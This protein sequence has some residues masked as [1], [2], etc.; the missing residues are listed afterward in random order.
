[1]ESRP[2]PAGLELP[3]LVA[4]TKPDV[5]R[6]TS[7]PT[8]FAAENRSLVELGQSLATLPRA[9]LQKLADVA[10]GL[11]EAHAVGDAKLLENLSKFAAA[12]YKSLASRDRLESELASQRGVEVLAASAGHDHHRLALLQHELRSHLAPAK[13]AC[14]LLQRGVLDSAATKRMCAIIDRQVDGMTRIVDELL[15]D[16]PL[17]P[18][19]VELHRREM[20]LEELIARSVELVAPLMAA[21]KHTLL[22]DIRTDSLRVEADELWLLHAVQNVISNA[23]KYT[24]P[25]GRIEVRVARDGAYAVISVHDTGVGLAPEQRETIFD[26]YMQAAQGAGRP[27]AGGLGVGLHFARFLIEAHG[28]DI[29]ATSKGLGR[30]SVFTIRLPCVPTCRSSGETAAAHAAA[31]R[32]PTCGT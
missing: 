4:G 6:P 17:R 28:G 5:G 26:L 7:R 24:D 31:Q 19:G 15:E 20:A 1:M 13:N 3:S 11:C 10:L 2:L 27:A 18:G 21:R 23:A 30:G 9:I 32:I 25:G 12:G 22:I 14:E 8:T 29:R 16:A